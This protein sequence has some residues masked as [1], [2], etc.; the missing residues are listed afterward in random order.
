MKRRNF[1]DNSYSD[2]FFMELHML[3]ILDLW[4]DRPV[5]IE[6]TLEFEQSVVL[7]V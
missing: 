6:L 4:R 7:T 2:I 3:S 1:L 5:C